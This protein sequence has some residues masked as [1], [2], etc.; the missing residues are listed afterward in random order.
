M[1]TNRIHFGIIEESILWVF[2]V[3]NG[4]P[5]NRNRSDYNVVQVKENVA[6]DVSARHQTK[7]A[8]YEHWDN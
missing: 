2:P 3:E 5:D 7:P 8:K 4:E 1:Q 6:V